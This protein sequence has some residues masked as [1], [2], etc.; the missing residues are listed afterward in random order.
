MESSCGEEEDVLVVPTGQA[1]VVD[2]PSVGGAVAMVFG[3]IYNI[4]LDIDILSM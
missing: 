3:L 4:N 2:L 1:V